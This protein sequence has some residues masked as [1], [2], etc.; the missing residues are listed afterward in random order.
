[1]VERRRKYLDIF[2]DIAKY[3]VMSGSL[4]SRNGL[5]GAITYC[6]IDFKIQI[7]SWQLGFIEE[8]SRLVVVLQLVQEK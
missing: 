8:T 7:V 1:M 3:I 2:N 4:L 5:R 6:G